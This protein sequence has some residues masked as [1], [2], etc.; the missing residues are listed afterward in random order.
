MPRIDAIP[1]RPIG[2]RSA[3]LMITWCHSDRYALGM[4]SKARA[5]APA[6]VCVVNFYRAAE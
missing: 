3:R 6:G 1:V 4:E 2:D 5:W